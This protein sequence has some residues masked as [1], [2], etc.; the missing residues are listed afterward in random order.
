MNK[1]NNNNR[2][3]LEYDESMSINST[4]KLLQS[5]NPN[6]NNIN[7]SSINRPNF[8]KGF[9]RD[10]EDLSEI[11]EFIKEKTITQGLSGKNNISNIK[12]T[13]SK[14]LDHTQKLSYSQ[15][16]GGD[17]SKLK[18]ENNIEKTRQSSNFEIETI[19]QNK[20]TVPQETVR[21]QQRKIS[22]DSNDREKRRRAALSGDLETPKSIGRT[23][24]IENITKQ[25]NH[26]KT[27]EIEPSK[28]KS[29]PKDPFTRKREERLNFFKILGFSLFFISI[30]IMAFLVWQINTLQSRLVEAEQALYE[31]PELATAM[32]EAHDEIE[33]LEEEIEQLLSMI[34]N[35]SQ[36]TET[37][38]I[39]NFDGDFT[40]PELQT[41]R[42]HIVQSGESL[43]IISM[44]LLGSMAYV[45]LIMQANGLTN[46]NIS[47]G[48]TLII[49]SLPN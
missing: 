36:N 42:H 14:N 34:Q 24:N 22:I 19:N 35:T 11:S 31:M 28:I 12:N 43:S 26:I 30:I 10:T 4:R 49:P 37:E 23:Q 20:K 16:Q 1:D 47:V 44:N 21:I 39:D 18:K 2:K 48:Q 38:I 40:P 27:K 41:D 33:M 13:Q 32:A 8:V 45:D 7:K 25:T 3:K 17:I 6:L 5:S 15:R 29:T 46:T 9:E